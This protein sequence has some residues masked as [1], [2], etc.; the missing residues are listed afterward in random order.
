MGTVLVTLD[1]RCVV[2]FLIFLYS[3]SGA[4]FCSSLLSVLSHPFTCTCPCSFTPILLINTRPCLFTPV[5]TCPCSCAHSCLF[6]LVQLY[7]HSSWYCQALN[8]GGGMSIVLI[9]DSMMQ[10][11]TIDFLSIIGTVSHIAHIF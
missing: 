11:P 10:G 1:S 3:Y 4:L 2:T 9:N 8:A 7:P 6:A 5:R